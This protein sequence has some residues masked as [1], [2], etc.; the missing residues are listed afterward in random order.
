M[1]VTITEQHLNKIITESVKKRLVEFNHMLYGSE[2]VPESRY[3]TINFA[4]GIMEN[5]ETQY[6]YNTIVTILR[7]L[8]LPIE[9][10]VSYPESDSLDAAKRNEFK[11]LCNKIESITPSSD[12]ER[13]ILTL[14]LDA[15]YHIEDYNLVQEYY[16]T[17]LEVP[18]YEPDPDYE[19][20]NKF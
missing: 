12:E 5:A 6:D 4:E 10:E 14:Y 3:G 11:E 18:D 19:H 9:M 15:V 16:G 7:N 20:D 13:A 1:K 8:G 17:E 2:P